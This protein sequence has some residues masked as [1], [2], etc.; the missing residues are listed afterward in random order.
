MAGKGRRPGL[1]Y[2]HIPRGGAGRKIQGATYP[3]WCWCSGCLL[4]S[5]VLLFELKLGKEWA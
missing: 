3:R 5:I 4:C 1:M 2:R